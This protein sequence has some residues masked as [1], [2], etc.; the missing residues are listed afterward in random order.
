MSD[1]VLQM[2]LRHLR[3]ALRRPVLL[4]FSLAQPLLWMTFFGFLF[5][6]TATP[7][8][9]KGVD[10]LTFVTPGISLLSVLFGASQSGVSLIRDIQTGFL[11]RMLSTATPALAILFGK[12]LADLV[13]LVLQAL[14]VVGLG[15]LLGADLTIVMANAPLAFLAVAGFALLMSS[16]SCLLAAL[17]RTPELMG[18]YVHLVNMPVLFTSTALIPSRHMPEWL[19][20]FATYN[21]LTVTVEALRALCL[22]WQGPGLLPVVALVCAASIMLVFSTLALARAARME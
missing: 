7:E 22:G 9:L 3:A 16:L 13:R 11:G 20:R 17:T 8:L 18:A 15:C 14:L 12:L 5:Q 21:P 4:T 1:A 19:A 2:C 10:Y 6:R